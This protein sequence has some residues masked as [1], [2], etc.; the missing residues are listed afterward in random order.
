VHEAHAVRPKFVHFE[1]E[2]FLKALI[3]GVRDHWDEQPKANGAKQK[4]TRTR[5]RNQEAR[6]EIDQ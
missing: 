2:H 1:V 3:H 5:T 4:R 6:T